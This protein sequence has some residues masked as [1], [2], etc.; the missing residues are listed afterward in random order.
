[1][2]KLKRESVLKLITF[3]SSFLILAIFIHLA[4]KFNFTFIVNFYQ[5]PDLFEV[6]SMFLKEVVNPTFM[7][8]VGISLLRVYSGF[9]AATIIAILFAVLVQ[10]N[11]LHV[12]RFIHPI[13]EMIRPIPNVAWVPFSILLFNSMEMSVGYITFVSAFFP[14]FINTLHGL[15]RVSLEYTR[16]AKMLK[17][18]QR[19]FVFNITLPASLPYIFTGLILGMSGAWLGLIVA[20]MINGRSGIGYYTWVNYTLINLN[21]VAVGMLTI[22]LLGAFST[23][24]LNKLGKR[25]LSWT[26]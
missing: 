22:G 3:S 18:T 9:L 16:V 13:L 19:A 25:M 2:L 5:L 24:M 12:G 23:W 15:Q 26:N 10:T 6:V 20:E 4:R 11:V 14:I 17:V 21:G 8:Y 1:M 7:Q